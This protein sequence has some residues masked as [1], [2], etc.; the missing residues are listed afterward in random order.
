MVPDDEWV[1]VGGSGKAKKG[2]KKGVDCCKRV[3]SI[4]RMSI[5]RPDLCVSSPSLGT[6]NSHGAQPPVH[7]QTPGAA[8]PPAVP[9]AVAPLPG[10]EAG[11]AVGCAQP[12]A[13]AKPRQGVML[14]ST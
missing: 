8:I 9:A 4:D 3:L 7:S 1:V 5:D 12:S 11:S 6:S 13:Q 14:D 2:S 10:W